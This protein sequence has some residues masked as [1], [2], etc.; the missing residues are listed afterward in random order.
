[1]LRLGLVAIGLAALWT[2]AASRFVDRFL[3][4]IIRACL[5]RW[6][7]LEVRDYARLLELDKGYTVSEIEIDAGDWLSN[8]R[9]SELSL[10]QEGVLV[11]GVRRA[12]G[13]HIGAPHGDTEILPGDT[14]SCY[15]PEKVLRDLSQRLSGPKGDATHVATVEGQDRI[16]A[17]ENQL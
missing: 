5:R 3:T 4:R 14:L 6:T 8:R 16:R 15:G 11:L 2:L 1:V 9:V 17:R 10:P 7:R 13:N 12:N